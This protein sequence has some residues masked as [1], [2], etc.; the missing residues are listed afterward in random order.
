MSWHDSLIYA[1]KV[2][3]DL[4]FDIDYI[5]KWVQPDNDQWFSFWV[6]PCTLIFETPTKFKL[7]LESSDIYNYIE[8]A[9]LHRQVNRSNRT[10]WRIETHV[11]DI[12]IEAECFKQFVRRQ[13]TLQSGQQ[14]IS[15]ERG[16]VS[17]ATT[18]DKAFIE[19]EQITQIKR[20]SFLLRQKAANAMQLQKSLSNLFDQ[21]MKNEIDT[22]KYILEKRKIEQQIKE[23]MQ[24]L[25][26]FDHEHLV[27]PLR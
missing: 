23:I 17:F 19:T 4:H 14:I 11:G 1:F 3:Q 20:E 10:E 27:D 26:K 22:K 18:F 15:E 8:I 6:A 16:E 2:D 9:D 24:E 7:D 25:K 13:P 21:R 12:I 5:F